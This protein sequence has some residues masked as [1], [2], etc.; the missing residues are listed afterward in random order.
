MAR[1]QSSLRNW[2]GTI[3]EELVRLVQ[4]AGGR[5]VF[6]EPP[7]SEV[8]MRSY[9]TKLRQEDVALFATPGA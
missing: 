9:R 8:F 2:H 7:Q 1:N 4:G 5:V 6:F 3:P